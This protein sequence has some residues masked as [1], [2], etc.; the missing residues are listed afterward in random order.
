MDNPSPDHADAAM[1]SN[2]RMQHIRHE[3][4][5]AFLQKILRVAATQSE[6]SRARRR[7]E[8]PNRALEVWESLVAGRWTFVDHFDHDGRRYLLAIENAPKSRGPDFLS[9]REREVIL[10]ALHGA[11][12]KVIAYDLGIQHSTVKVLMSRAATKMGVHTRQ[13]LL[14]RFRQMVGA[15][16]LDLRESR[17]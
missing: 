14:D 12:N 2:G 8:D 10:R 16:Q 4:V 7:R 15:E 13:Q 17:Y 6:A 9:P 5:D 1:D 3:T 11:D